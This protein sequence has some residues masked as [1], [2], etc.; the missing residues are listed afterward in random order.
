MSNQ[1]QLTV[2]IPSYLEAE[3]LKFLLPQL[4][5]AL[6]DIP[7]YE[8]LIV[9]TPEARDET[10]DVCKENGVRYI[11]RDG[12][13]TYSAAVTTAIAK[14]EG[15]FL[16]FMDGDGS[17]DPNL[18]PE[19]FSHRNDYDIVAAS[20]Y[21]GGGST[22]N[23]AVLGLMSKTLNLTYRI[24]LNLDAYDISNSFKLYHTAPL[25]DLTLYCTNFDIIEEIMVKLNR[26]KKV[27]VKE[28]PFHFRERVHGETK[29]NL[30][31]FIFSYASTLIKLRF[32]K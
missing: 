19:L 10:P 24:V 6:K 14:A 18:I 4:K 30:V 9:D 16:L 2:A 26:I 32:G 31:T 3:N 12:G 20:R 25:R 15:E 27:K 5:E 8:I 21:V 17:H 28:I 13:D 7:N 11:N 29:R 22:D 1:I 23:N